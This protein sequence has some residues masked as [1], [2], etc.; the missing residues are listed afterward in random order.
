MSAQSQMSTLSFLSMSTTNKLSIVNEMMAEMKRLV[1][2]ESANESA[3]KAHEAM[4][5]Y[6]EG[7]LEE[8]LAELRATKAELAQTNVAFLSTKAELDRIRQSQRESA[9][10]SYAKTKEEDPEKY[11]A[12]LEKKRQYAAAKKAQQA[13]KEAELEAYRALHANGGRI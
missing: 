9:K 13:Q 12:V 10:R 3:M 8:A 6:L 7:E 5:D 1:Q 2:N 4:K 11:Q